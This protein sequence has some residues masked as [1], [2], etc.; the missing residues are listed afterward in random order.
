MHM[1]PF[2][3]PTYMSFCLQ[4]MNKNERHPYFF[5]EHW[6]PTSKTDVLEN[7]HEIGSF[8]IKLPYA[9]RNYIRKLQC[10]PPQAK[11][12]L[13]DIQANA[14]IFP[15]CPLMIFNCT[16]MIVNL[17]NST[18]L[19][20]LFE[21]WIDTKV[22]WRWFGTPGVCRNTHVGAVVFC[23]DI[24]YH[25]V[26]FL[27]S[28]SLERSSSDFFHMSAPGLGLPVTLHITVTF[29]PSTVS[30]ISGTTCTK[31]G[32]RTP[33]WYKAMGIT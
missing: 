7:N 19:R 27:P 21:S 1:S 3:L 28:F 29:L 24:Q 32:P 16:R 12:N 10:F 20:C 8:N 15:V 4:K 23:S 33:K 26:S 25:E 2:S 6:S 30:I 22:N 11:Y 31:G 14:L 17:M 18:Y 5:S 13:T 9:I